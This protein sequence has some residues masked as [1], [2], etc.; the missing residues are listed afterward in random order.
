MKGKSKEGYTNI[1]LPLPSQRQQRQRKKVESKVS[2]CSLAEPAMRVDRKNFGGT[3]SAIATTTQ[4]KLSSS[5]TTIS[6]SS[7]SRGLG[8][9]RKQRKQQKKKKME[10]K[11]KE[12]CP[13]VST[14]TGIQ[15]TK[16]FAKKENKIRTCQDLDANVEIMIR[17]PLHNSHCRSGSEMKRLLNFWS[18]EA[19]SDGRPKKASPLSSSTTMTTRTMSSSSS[20]PRGSRCKGGHRKKQNR[21]KMKGKSKEGYTNIQL[22]LPSQRQQRQRKKVES[23]VSKCSLAEPAMRVDRKNFGGTCSAIATITQPQPVCK[24]VYHPLT[25]NPVEALKERMPKNNSMDKRTKGDFCTQPVKTSDLANTEENG[26]RTLTD[27]KLDTSTVAS[28]KMKDV[29]EEKE[30]IRTSQD[31]D[32]DDEKS[33]KAPPHNSHCL[34]ECEMKSILKSC[35]KFWSKEATSNGR[36]KKALPGVVR[37]PPCPICVSSA[38]PGQLSKE[39]LRRVVMDTVMIALKSLNLSG[40]LAQL[41]EST[42][43]N[44]PTRMISITRSVARTSL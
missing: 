25:T 31:L 17:A 15:R 1:Q 5:T 26:K 2:K 30:K 44:H 38:P 6:S 18:K 36:P 20:P 16:G 7:S 14:T 37:K 4:P 27:T 29:T 43:N 34:S 39:E 9:K 33:I 41:H 22:P 23:K 11:T 3:C 8:S 28:P 35:S 21:K 19:T 12:G 10:S 24:R 40:G 42:R 13:V 32:T